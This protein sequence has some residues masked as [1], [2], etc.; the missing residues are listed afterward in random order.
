MLGDVQGGE[1]ESCNETKVVRSSFE[2][3][4]EIR[5]RC[6]VRIYKIARREHYLVIYDCVTAESDLAQALVDIFHI[7]R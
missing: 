5:V 1:V 6:A 3:A 2:S 7:K 4:E